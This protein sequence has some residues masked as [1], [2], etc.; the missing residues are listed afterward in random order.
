MLSFV[1]IALYF[2]E[3]CRCTKRLIFFIFL[4]LTEKIDWSQQLFTDA[5][6]DPI[7]PFKTNNSRSLSKNTPTITD[8]YENVVSVLIT[9]QLLEDV[10]ASFSCYCEIHVNYEN[11]AVQL[12]SQFSNLN[13][14]MKYIKFLFF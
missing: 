11:K 2:S 1:P 13:N 8:K 3:M 7:N 10:K 6:S 5:H 4:A 9:A 14:I 12:S